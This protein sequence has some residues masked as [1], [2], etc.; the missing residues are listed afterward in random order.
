MLKNLAE[1]RKNK[2]FSQDKL[3]KAMGVTGCLI[4]KWERGPYMPNYS[5]LRKL[6]TVLCCTYDDLLEE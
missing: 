2:G 6:K 4:S 1:I 3:S 5:N